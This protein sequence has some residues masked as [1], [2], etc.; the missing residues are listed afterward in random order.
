VQSAFSAES[1]NLIIDETEE[2]SR[3]RV[4]ERQSSGK[5]NLVADLE[6]IFEV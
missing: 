3:L 1:Q 2:R 5:G 6:D 4:Q